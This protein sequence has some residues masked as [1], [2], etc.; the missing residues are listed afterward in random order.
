MSG[1]KGTR[2]I[3][4]RRFETYKVM[5]NLDNWG[6]KRCQ[7]LNGRQQFPNGCVK[8]IWGGTQ[9]VSLEVVSDQ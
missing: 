9:K 8:I 7:N 6:G 2:A 1:A 5:T 4:I 3:N